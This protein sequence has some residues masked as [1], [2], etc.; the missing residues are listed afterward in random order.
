MAPLCGPR[1]SPIMASAM[2]I[3]IRDAT[4]VTGDAGRTIHHGAAVAIDGDRIA[5]VGPT[6]DLAPRFPGAEVVDGRGK[7]VFP[8]FVNCHTHL[9]FTVAR[10]IQED[11]GF[12]S[13]LRFPTTAQAMLSAEETRVFA[14]LGAL[15]ALRSGTTTLLEIGYRVP[16]Y[17]EALA[18]TGLRLVLGQSTSDLEPAGI[19]DGRFDFSPALG[20]KSLRSVGDV[21]ARWHGA[22]HGRIRCVVAAHAPE[23]CSPDNL[24]QARALAERH[25]VGT[26]IHMNQSRWEVEAVMRVRGVRPVEYVFEHGFLGPRLVAA[27]CRFMTPSEIAL[28][29]GSGAAISHNAAMAARRAAAPP[30][31]ALA[32][33]GCTIALGTDNMAEDMVEAMR[34]ALFMERVRL[35]DAQRPQPEDVLEW[36]TRGGARALGL[37]DQVGALEVGRKADLV[38]VD[39]R[40]PHL[41]PTLRI[42]SGFVHN[43][44]AGDVEA[45]MVDGRFVLRDGRA[46]TID[47]ADVVA[48][49]EA[50]ARRVWRALVDRYPDVPFPIRL[51]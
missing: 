8:G 25:D 16:D 19:P 31:Q 6:A 14:L 22:E 49:A 15:E 45:V 39:A 18:A 42:V 1:G 46:L 4:I 23:A 17:A 41:V 51:P 40:R 32:A 10:G 44:Q 21:I 38:L 34:T 48:R 43:G 37:A 24:R 33:A 20:E 47:E 36:A 5:A 7:A 27:H 3:L 9:W 11:F 30:I 50:I 26:T 12:P 35:E 2:A 28:L 13:T 29:G